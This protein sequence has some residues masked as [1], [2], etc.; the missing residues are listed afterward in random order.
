MDDATA[1]LLA[2]LPIIDRYSENATLPAGVEGMTRGGGT[3]YVLLAPGV[4]GGAFVSL[5]PM[6]ALG[7][8]MEI[9]FI[10][11]DTGAMG[12]FA[13]WLF[14]GSV[15]PVDVPDVFVGRGGGGSVCRAAPISEVAFLFLPKKLI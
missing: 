1:L 10:S 7:G 4:D 9:R 5:A 11:F 14:P 15:V 13:C 2:V 6:S 12:G 3:V 8:R